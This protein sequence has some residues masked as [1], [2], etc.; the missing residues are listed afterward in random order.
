MT[1]YDKNA[2]KLS[3]EYIRAHIKE[4]DIAVDATAG[5][6]RDT[7]LLCTLTG[8]SGKVFS[9]D[10]QNDALLSTR[11]LLDEHNITNAT[12]I[13]DSHH[14]LRDYVKSAKGVVFNFGFLP[15]GDHSI[16]SHSEY[17][18]ENSFSLISNLWRT[19]ETTK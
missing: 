4:G 10:I 19:V 5:R 15:G 1:Y 9:F 17:N 18:F 12:L 2:L 14:K 6:G 16:F 3:H 11:T 13:L 8:S 7:L